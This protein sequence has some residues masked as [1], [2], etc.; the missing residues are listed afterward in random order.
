MGLG[1]LKDL[2]GLCQWSCHL[3][4]PSI[5]IWHR[6]GLA[7]ELL[8][9]LVLLAVGPNLVVWLN[10]GSHHIIHCKEVSFTGFLTLIVILVVVVS[11]VVYLIDIRSNLLLSNH[12]LGLNYWLLGLDLGAVIYYIFA[13]GLVITLNLNLQPIKR[14]LLF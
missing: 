1:V 3:V 8:L 2:T 9:H 11:G 4:L 5:V 7:L 10:W 6:I 13:C 12:L 14:H